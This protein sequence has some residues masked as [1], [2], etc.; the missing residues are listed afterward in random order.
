M[1]QPIVAIVGRPN[2]G[3]STLFNRLIGRKKAIVDDRP[4]VT[5]DRNYD[6]VA[7]NGQ[8][9]DLIDTGG[10]LPKSKALMDTAIKEQVEIAIDEADLIMLLV[11]AK[12]GITDVDLIIANMLRKS[13]AE[14]LLVV[15]KVDDHRDDS[16]T[17]A[18]YKLGLGDPVPVSGMTGRQSGDLLDVLVNKIKK[19]N[20]PE[21]EDERIKL[22][23]IGR[24]NSGK[25]S[26]LNM[27]VGESRSIVSEIPGTTRDALD[28]ELN[29]QKRKYLLIDTAGLKKKRRVKENILFYSNLR[30]HRSV[31]RADVVLYMVDVKEGLSKQ[32]ISLIADAVAQNKGILLLLNKWDLIEKDHKTIE[33]YKEDNMEKLGVF[34]YI[35]Q[36]YTSVIEKQ[37][38]F[39]AIDLATEIYFKR[40]KKVSTSELNDFFLPLINEFTPPAVKGKEIKINYVTQVKAAPPVFAF[41][42]NFPK[43]IGET[44]RRFLENRFRKKFDFEGVPLTFS[45]RKK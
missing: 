22:A 29:Y 17:G 14:T 23:I 9:F 34:R 24:E 13:K 41:Y 44:Y 16:E 35:P 15:T 26:L 31:Q 28:S 2:V 33:K 38:L 3:K 4:G 10:Y 37:R 19:Y 6:A 40:Q 21:N 39:K 42:S 36:I 18:F 1:A 45:F 5:R 11:D 27:L 25:S 7:W 30:T 12:T 8:Q 32:D 20:I 43:L